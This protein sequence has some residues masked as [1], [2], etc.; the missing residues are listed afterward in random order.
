MGG[1]WVLYSSKDSKQ[2]LGNRKQVG[3]TTSPRIDATAH[4]PHHGSEVGDL[5]ANARTDTHT[6]RT[7]FAKLQQNNGLYFKTISNGAAPCSAVEACE[8]ASIPVF[9]TDKSGQPSRFESMPHGNQPF[10]SMQD[11]CLY[12]P[13]QP[14]ILNLLKFLWGKKCTLA[15]RLR[16]LRTEPPNDSHFGERTPHFYA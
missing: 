8:P 15:V 1:T 2:Q 16:A 12:S 13:E 7:A 4:A 3:L 14:C 9:K 10:L 5:T 11:L 6:Y